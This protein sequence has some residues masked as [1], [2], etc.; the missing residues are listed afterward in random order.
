ML[1]LVSPNPKHTT[2]PA[3]APEAPLP[4][5]YFNQPR[6]GTISSSSSRDAQQEPPTK[7]YEA[8][9]GRRVRR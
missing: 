4:K 1:L 5:Q 9:G 8:A 7:R 6:T 3:R 2:R